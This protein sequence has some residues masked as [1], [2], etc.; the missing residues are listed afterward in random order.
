MVLVI[1]IAP[2]SKCVLKDFN[3]T[4][5]FQINFIHLHCWCC[6]FSNL[7]S[8]KA[9]PLHVLTVWCKAQGDWV[10][11]QRSKRNNSDSL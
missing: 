2:I 3:S 11:N 5:S 8:F 7:K 9:V 6:L 4:K 10:S 1:L